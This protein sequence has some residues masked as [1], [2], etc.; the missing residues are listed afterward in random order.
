[1]AAPRFGPFNG[2]ARAKEAPVM[3]DLLREF[4]SETSEGL[5]I[6]DRDLVEVERNPG[7]REVIARIFRVLH[8]IK[9]TSGFLNLQRLGAVAHAAETLL[10]KLRDG[11]LSVTPTAISVILGA[12]DRIKVILAGIAASGAEPHGD[13]ADLI[14]KLEAAALREATQKPVAAGEASEAPDP[15]R[16]SDISLAGKTIRVSVDLIEHLMTMV[17]ELVL[18][19]NQLLEM[20]RRLQESEFKVPL[21]RLS[22]ITG[23]L[24]EGVMRTRMQPIGIAWQKLPRI[25]RDLGHELGKK[26]EL[27]MSGAET[28][29]DRQVLELI[30]DPLTHMVRNSADHGIERPEERRAAGKPETG[31]IRLSARHEGGHII[32]V[33]ADD[34]RGLD[35]ERIKARAV[36]EGLTSEA[37]LERLSPSQIHNF[38]F[39]PGFS[40]AAAVS[41]I[42][43]RGVGLDV[44]RNNI[45]EI[46]GTID[47]RSIAGEGTSFTIKIPLTLAI[48]STLIVGAG[49]ERFAFPQI[50]VVE[51][52]RVK[53]GSEHRIERINA[54]P[55]LRLRQRLLPLVHL[56]E[57]LKLSAAPAEPGGDSEAFVI[58]AQVG[59]RTFGIVVDEVF[60]TEEIVVKPMASRLRHLDVFSGTTI[61]GDGQ[62]IMIL[63][64]NGIA[65]NVGDADSEKETKTREE[66]RRLFNA[67]TR[68]PLLLFSAGMQ[69]PKAVPL[70]LVT[71]LEEIEVAKIE[72]A[73]GRPVVQYRGKLMPL[74]PADPT[75]MFRTSGRQPV[76]VF[77]SEQRSMGL[78]VDKI[79][80]IVEEVLK[81]ELST[82]SPG[83]V[84]S[85]V[86]RG[87]TTRILDVGHFLKAADEDWFEDELDTAR[88]ARKQVLVVDGNPFFRN[89]VS[90]LLMAAGYDVTAVDSVE[91]ALVLK[92]E[93][94]RYD[95]IVSEIEMPGIDGL[96]FARMLKDDPSWRDARLLALSRRR[97]PEDVEETL[98]AG[99]HG[100]VPKLDRDALI[101]AVCEQLAAHEEAA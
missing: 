80:D 77:S 19:R 59:L 67:E 20:V 62:V 74:V 47:L 53:T 4:L 75:V 55:I 99:F 38:V 60:D 49:G 52:V 64:P 65:A 15:E 81:I 92:E 33:V 8:T 39:V 61:L 86:I 32:I 79:D 43:G 73:N 5:E 41:S 36:K 96:C 51:L 10:G 11:T 50:A 30:K 1:M 84:G 63:D 83:V 6:I 98:K 13:D 97:T 82:D 76:V 14:A 69:E 27:E 21:Q 54:T 95:L 90:P 3:D 42:S 23:E 58:V 72:S 28:E 87:R 26:I 70:A 78:V 57:L 7:N 66:E 91:A 31:R 71:R 44:V 29:L 46:G 16:T 12:V 17:R 40:T 24:Q 48:V 85:A 88:S 34:G 25:V 18:T 35:I 37:D 101:A 89:L 22:N 9:G 100:Y 45:Q 93:G 2:R 68:T 94:R 56:S